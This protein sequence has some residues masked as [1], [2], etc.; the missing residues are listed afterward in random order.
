MSGE[1]HVLAVGVDHNRCASHARNVV[2][3]TVQWRGNQWLSFGGSPLDRVGLAVFG[4]V[5]LLVS[6]ATAS[7]PL[8]GGR[9][10]GFAAGD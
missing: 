1:K 9:V 2:A 7:L 6:Q 8:C 5:A 3:A 4:I 10:Q